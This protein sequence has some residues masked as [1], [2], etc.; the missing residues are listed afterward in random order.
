M[1]RITRTVIRHFGQNDMDAPHT[2]QVWIWRHPVLVVIGTK[3]VALDRG[4]LA[5][6]RASKIA[7]AS[8]SIPREYP[9][10]PND[11]WQSPHP[12]VNPSNR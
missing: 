3:Q 5:L 2:I 1:N 10:V 9:F 7:A 8:F 4:L 6:Y 11:R 12:G